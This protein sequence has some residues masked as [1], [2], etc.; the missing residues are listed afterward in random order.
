M[1]DSVCFDTDTDTDTDTHCF[2]FPCCARCSLWVLSFAQDPVFTPNQHY[3]YSELISVLHPLIKTI[4]LEVRSKLD[5][6]TKIYE[7]TSSVP[8]TYHYRTTMKKSL[9]NKG[10]ARTSRVPLF[11]DNK[12]KRSVASFCFGTNCSGQCV[13]PHANR[14]ENAS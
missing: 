3:P 1:N 12:S 6:K 8:L 11:E 7:C 10:Q 9:E 2:S 5:L 14:N 13:W 4:I